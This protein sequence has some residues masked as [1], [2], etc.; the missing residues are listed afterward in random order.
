MLDYNTPDDNCTA[1][2]S[3]IKEQNDEFDSIVHSGLIRS[4]TPEFVIKNLLEYLQAQTNYNKVVAEVTLYR[5]IDTSVDYTSNEPVTYHL[6]IYTDV[7]AILVY[8]HHNYLGMVTGDYTQQ[9][10]SVNSHDEYFF[11]LLKSFVGTLLKPEE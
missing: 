4:V 3:T 9:N 7:N 5:Y 10:E 6:E 2:V 8:S 1:I 11:D